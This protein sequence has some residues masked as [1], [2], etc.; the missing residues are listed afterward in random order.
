MSDLSG[1]QQRRERRSFS[2]W[3]EFV[4]A[5]LVALSEVETRR[6]SVP[7][8][9]KAATSAT[10]SNVKTDTPTPRSRPSIT[11]LRAVKPRSLEPEEQ[12][13]N[14]QREIDQRD[15]PE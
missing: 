12:H 4:A 14:R 13:E 5:E 15:H 8:A 10:S 3:D 6:L 11:R 2:Q 9:S 7:V 1:L